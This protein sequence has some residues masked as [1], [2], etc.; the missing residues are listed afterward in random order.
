MANTKITSANLDTLTTLTV[1]DITID[2][3]TISDSGDLTLDVGG[4]IILDAGGADIRFKDDGT[5]FASLIKSGDNAQL[6]SI[7]QDGDLMFRGYDSSSL[8]TALTLDMSNAGDALFKSRIFAGGGT[9]TNTSV[10]ADDLV[11]GLTDNATERGL[12]IASTVGGGIRWND[13][14]DSGVIQYSHSSNE[15]YYSSASHHRFVGT[16]DAAGMV[17]INTSDAGGGVLNVKSADVA[18]DGVGSIGIQSPNSALRI[19]GTSGRSWIQSHGSQPLYINKLGNN[20]I[21]NADAGDV[22]IGLTNP[23]S[24]YATDLVVSAAA[25]KG[26]TIAATATNAANYLMF[27]DGTSGDARYRGYLAYN[28]AADELTLRSADFINFMTGGGTERARF[29]SSG[30]L[31]L[32]ITDPDQALEIG[33]AGK[34]KLSRADNARSML[35]FTDNSYGTIQ[36]DVDPIL[37]QSANRIDFN[38]NGANAAL[39]INTNGIVDASKYGGDRS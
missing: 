1:D 26:I 31:G 18:E 12:T 24:Y 21:L 15:M 2:G 27:A 9:G 36:T 6:I 39:R 19:G 37:I 10:N 28:H 5:H 11:L 33:A 23:S 14:A 38:A 3:S 17:K 32:G 22:G 20:V 4:D 7:V 34:L 13:G 25:E 35:L 30:R 29:D 8:I 16:A